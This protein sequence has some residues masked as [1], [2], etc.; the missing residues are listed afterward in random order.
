[1]DKPPV[2]CIQTGSRQRIS[3]MT[4]RRIVKELISAQ[5]MTSIVFSSHETHDRDQNA[6]L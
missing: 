1:M 5:D 6:T 2:R 3:S 4:R